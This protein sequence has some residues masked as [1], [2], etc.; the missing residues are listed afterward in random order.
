MIIL[1]QYTPIQITNHNGGYLPYALEE[2]SLIIFRKN[3]CLVPYKC[4]GAIN[5]YG[6]YPTE[7]ASSTQNYKKMA[8]IPNQTI[9]S[10]KFTKKKYVYYLKSEQEPKT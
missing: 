4:K 7:F 10:K 9:K 2:D 3:G 5:L 6:G 8:G 1:E